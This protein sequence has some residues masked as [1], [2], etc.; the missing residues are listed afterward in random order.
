[1]IIKFECCDGNTKIP[2][3]YIST[4]N[5][6]IH[7]LLGEN[8][9]Y[10]D[11]F[12]D[13]CVSPI[14]DGDMNHKPHIDIE[15]K[16]LTLKKH[17]TLYVSSENEDFI[18]TLVVGSCFN[19]A[20]LFG[21]KPKMSIEDF[22]VSNFVDTIECH[23]LLLKT[24]EGVK[25]TVKDPQWITLLTEQ[26]KKKL[27]HKN[28]EDPDFKIQIFHGEGAREKRCYVGD[29]LNIC[30]MVRLKIYGKPQTRKTLYNMGLGNST[31]CGFGF[32]KL[33]SK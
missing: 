12:S 26:C 5:G 30:S 21:V 14:Y 20:T 11:K 10:H 1:M 33:Y 6:F 16:T 23:N 17:A 4:V 31:G 7:T 22:S 3:N 19:N 8:N 15:T 2:S 13:Y 24:K 18:K 29:V 32:I 27:K 9:E 28:I 25:I